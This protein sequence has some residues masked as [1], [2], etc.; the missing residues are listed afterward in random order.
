[1]ATR[2]KS[3]TIGQSQT[4]GLT[5]DFVLKD[6]GAKLFADY[7]ADHVGEY[8]AIVLDGKVISAPVI[9]EPIPERPGP[10]LGRRHRRASRPP[11][12]TNS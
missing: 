3:A 7:T 11:R 8:F 4:Q 1:M 2:C 10:D 9:N 12:P 6:E 5:V